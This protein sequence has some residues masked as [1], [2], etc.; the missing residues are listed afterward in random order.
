MR[1]RERRWWSNARTIGRGA[2]AACLVL[3]L[4]TPAVAQT[5][6]EDGGATGPQ[7]SLFPPDQRL[8]LQDTTPRTDP[9]P[10]VSAPQEDRRPDWFWTSVISGGAFVGS[11]L[12][13]VFDGEQHSYHLGNE[14]WFGRKSHF[15]GADKAAHFVDYY[16]LSKEFAHAFVRLGHT[17]ESA[18]WLAAGVSAL[19][20]LVTEIGD[21]SNRYGFAYEDLVMDVG[22]A[23]SAALINAA[24]AEDLIG[25]R[26][27]I[28]HFDNCCNYGNEIYTAD[29]DLSGAARRLGLSIGPL[30]YLFLSFTYR[31]DGGENRQVGFEVGLNFKQIL[32]DLNVRRQHW[33]GY[34][35][36]VV[37][38]NV[39]FPYTA[40]GVRYNIN[41]GRWH[42]PNAGY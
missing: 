30:K 16:V 4:A 17:P 2:S 6:V 24:G 11:A 29:L 19:T 40:L 28:V 32:N 13:S 21:G 27:G 18:R 20:G 26:R 9:A 35:L 10:V 23:L 22:G 38:D 3:L 5:A 34:A 15:G 25:F 39:R 8:T 36:H 33:W 1:P 37:F 12:N 14:G 31:A 7:Y 42:G 41:Q